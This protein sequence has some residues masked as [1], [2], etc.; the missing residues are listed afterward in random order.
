MSRIAVIPEISR[1]EAVQA[2]LIEV[3]L[4]RDR[5]VETG[6]QLAEAHS[7]S[8]TAKR[9]A[10]SLIVVDGGVTKEDWDSAQTTWQTAEEDL[11]LVRQVHAAA[12]AAL[13]DAVLHLAREVLENAD[14][15]RLDLEQA[16]VRLDA[17][18]SKRLATFRST[19]Q[20]RGEVAASY[21]WIT[22]LIENDAVSAMMG[23]PR[24]LYRPDSVRWVT[25]L[26]GPSGE[27]IF[28]PQLL[29]A[30][31]ALLEATGM[32]RRLDAAAAAAAER[33]ETERVFREQRELQIEEACRRQQERLKAIGGMS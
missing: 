27:P 28:E 16:W 8:M 6:Q 29:E 23:H 14:G 31:N 30:L 24:D 18:A 20:E 33:E 1:P 12:E 7:V 3:E 32:Q 19:E 15:W 13:R 22:R 26:R 10:N 11:A 21:Y 5:V 17:Q 4:A 2:A 9:Q 25:E